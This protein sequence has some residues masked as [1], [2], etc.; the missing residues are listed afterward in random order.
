MKSSNKRK[1]QNKKMAASTHAGM[2]SGLS[3]FR[4][5]YKASKRFITFVLALVLV[6]GL[7][8]VG[9]QRSTAKAADGDLS[10]ADKMNASKTT[11]TALTDDVFV[12]ELYLRTEETTVIVPLKTLT[13][14]T[15]DFSN[16]GNP[17][18]NDFCIW[19]SNALSETWAPVVDSATGEFSDDGIDNISSIDCSTDC[20][21]Y[22]HRFST[23]KNS[24]TNEWALD[25]SSVS[26]VKYNFK[27]EAPAAPTI[28]KS[29][30]VYTISDVSDSENTI[31]Y[32]QYVYSAVLTTDTEITAFDETVSATKTAAEAASDL[33]ADGDAN[34]GTY[35]ITKKILTSNDDFIYGWSGLY[36]RDDNMGDVDFYFTDESDNT[37]T[38]SV[39]ATENVKYCVVNKSDDNIKQADLTITDQGSGEGLGGATFSDLKKDMPVGQFMGNAEADI[40]EH[41][42]KAY[43]FT[44]VFSADGK[45][46]KTVTATL[47]YE[48]VVPKVAI[49]NVS[50]VAYTDGDG[51]KYINGDTAHVTVDFSAAGSSTTPKISAADIIAEPSAYCS[52]TASFTNVAGQTGVDMTVAGVSEGSVDLS[53]NITNSLGVK[54]ATPATQ[55]LIF[56]TSAP[57]I[58]V[59]KVSQGS[60]EYNTEQTS[61]FTISDDYKFTSSQDV[62]MIVHVSDSVSGLAADP[63]A[64]WASTDYTVE[65]LTGGDYKIT[66]PAAASNRGVDPCVQIAATDNVG[67]SETVDVTFSFIPDNVNVTAAEIELPSNGKS[68]GDIYNG[69][70]NLVYT[71]ESDVALNKDSISLTATMNGSAGE[72]LK[73]KAKK[74]TLEPTENTDEYKVVVELAET[75]T[76]KFDNIDFKINNTNGYESNTKRITILKIDMTDPE[77]TSVAPDSSSIAGEDGWYNT[78]YLKIVYSDPTVQTISSGIAS[79]TLNQDGIDEDVPLGSSGYS[80]AQVND[81]KNVNGTKVKVTAVDKVGNDYETDELTYYVDHEFTGDV[82]LIVNSEGAI[83]TSGDFL[84]DEPVINAK[85]SDNIGVKDYSIK[86][87]QNGT[88]LTAYSIPDISTINAGIDVNLK[89]VVEAAGKTLDDGDYVVNATA[90]DLAGNTKNA[91]AVSFTLDYKDPEIDEITVSQ[92]NSADQTISI[93]DGN[94]AFEN[95]VSRQFDLSFLVTGVQDVNLDA[96]GIT[97]TGPNG[98]ITSNYDSTAKTLTFTVS[99]ADMATMGYGTKTFT[100]TLTDAA[101]NVT[102]RDVNIKL[103]EDTIKVTYSVDDNFEQ[104]EDEDFYQG[105][106]SSADIAFVI[107]SDSKVEFSKLNLKVDG[108]DE[109]L[110]SAS[111]TAVKEEDGDYEYTYSYSLGG[112]DVKKEFEFSAENIYGLSDATDVTAIGFDMTT[113]DIDADE[114]IRTKKGNDDWYQNLVLVVKYDDDQGKVWSSGIEAI[115]VESGGGLTNDDKTSSGIDDINKYLEEYLKDPAH[116]KVGQFLIDVDESTLYS[117]GDIRPTEVRIRVKDKTGRT[118]K[119]EQSFKV[120]KHRP[121]VSEFKVE[122]DGNDVVGAKATSRIFGKNTTDATINVKAE[123]NIRLH[124]NKPFIIV[125][126]PTFSGSY[127]LNRNKQY[128]NES[129]SL[130]EIIK[131]DELIDGKYNIALYTEDICGNEASKNPLSTNIWLD[132][133]EPT[134]SDIEVSQVG[135]KAIQKTETGY[136]QLTASSESKSKGVFS[137]KF[138]AE[139]IVSNGYSSKINENGIEIREELSD[140][141]ERLYYLKDSADHK[142]KFDIQTDD[143]YKGKTIKYTI[144]V[145]DGAGNSVSKSLYVSFTTDLIVVNSHTEGL[146]TDNGTK[147]NTFKIIYEIFSA[148]PITKNESAAN[149][150]ADNIALSMQS[151]HDG[152]LNKD[153]AGSGK[154]EKASTYDAANSKYDYVYTYIVNRSDSDKLTDIVMSVTNNNGVKSE[155]NKISYVNIDL[156]DPAIIAEGLPE[157]AETRWYQSLP[158]SFSYNDGIREYISGVA[159]IQISNVKQALGDYFQTKFDTGKPDADG[160]VINGTVAVDVKESEGLQGTVVELQIFDKF[161]RGFAKQYR[162]HV[163]ETNPTVSLSVNG[164][165]AADVNGAYLG[166]DPVDPAVAF[167]VS[168]NIQ[169]QDYNLVI[170][171]PSG[172]TVTAAAGSDFKEF[173]NSTTLAGLIGAENCNGNVPKDGEYTIT[174]SAKD[175]A[176]RVP[177]GGNMSTT[178]VLDNT[179]P[180]NDLVVTSEKPAKFDKYKNAYTNKITNTAYEYGQ[181]YNTDVNFNAIVTD[182]NVNEFVV[183]D[184]GAAIY[185]GSS[186]GTFGIAVS[187]EGEHNIVINTTDKT[188]LT[189]EA[190][191]IS[192]T[193]DRGAPDLGVSLNGS[194]FAEGSGIR[195]LNTN[196]DVSVSVSDANLDDDDLTMTVVTTPPNSGS[197]TSESKVQPGSQSFAQEAEYSVKFV[198][199]DRAGNR[200]AERTVTFRVDK[201]PPELKFTGAAERGT[202]TSS[203]TM[204]YIVNEA[205]YSDM[206]GCSLRVYRKIDG[207]GESLLKTVEIKPSGP[208]YSMSE[209]FQEDGEYRFEMAAEDKCGNKSQASYTFILDSKAPII[210]LTGVGNYDKTIEDVIL[211]I[212]IDETFFSSN[213]VSI[214]GTRIDIDGKKHDVE[215]EGFNANGSKVSTF[216]QIF[217]EDGIYDISI[218]A[219]DKAGNSTSKQLHF[220]I[221][222][223]DPEINGIDDYDGKAVKSFNMNVDPDSM[224]K[225]L[226]VCTT[227]VY[228]DGVE[229]DGT[230]NLSDGAHLLNVVATDELGHTT[231]KKAAFKLDS[232]APN[233]LVSGVEEGQY[234]KVPT[235]INVT[236]ELDTDTLTKVSL[237]GQDIPVNDGIAKFTVDSRMAY[238]LTAEAVDE[239]GNVS[240]LEMHFNFGEKFPW[241][242]FLVGGGGLVLI[243]LVIGISR[244][245]DKKKQ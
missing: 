15:H 20:S 239:A 118:N 192:F 92:T 137:L 78:L 164:R 115:K 185:S 9:V 131:P 150:N 12:A 68:D 197:S 161:G 243:G 49:T 191:S 121:T 36:V 127:K 103:L 80:I 113:P 93:K 206:N 244:K 182:E 97:V 179:A 207:Q 5:H 73:A 53:F 140:G 233:I 212:T 91:T 217:K 76:V 18:K 107:K 163:D 143:S 7:V 89:D 10:F 84:K 205:F 245:K 240:K 67:L 132:Y 22:L 33:S 14:D 75:D 46:D 226:T 152:N 199:V 62:E 112:I 190:A 154:L 195:Y 184:N 77:I 90:K 221:D 60:I 87:K 202:S 231:E 170:T 17:D 134:L 99:A 204:N 159:T 39:D 52:T 81:S 213:K 224:I 193:I 50:T 29:N 136:R 223:T 177:D 100:I 43:D 155:E 139:D 54:A 96:S 194:P 174:L 4:Q 138:S 203:V 28:N 30:Y 37:I 125:T 63:T 130:A 144:T 149:L 51:N 64:K 86:V 220:T 171:L 196:G 148:A 214:S 57:Q 219:T 19:G 168:D 183:T 227:S 21:V 98:E 169:V 66:I 114:S 70:V 225:D 145:T 26:S 119:Y 8:Y 135:N 128:I 162:F 31:Y 178:F 82:D 42:G 69:N 189:S 209:L 229:Y 122:V 208:Q 111:F 156:N 166:G 23:V 234:I 95:S 133:T 24:E 61:D 222:R 45:K 88:D 25:T 58:T 153:T 102:E 160:R 109:T 242:I 181:Y 105:K 108:V 59:K 104:V 215:F 79:I 1:N 72:D 117:N 158:L 187:S 236:V 3:K 237:N 147:D 40:Y 232:T 173:S 175:I 6:L 218:V 210:T 123:D 2:A 200:S 56:D 188:G 172:G 176:G 47:K 180:T 55:T 35:I 141:S 129:V 241:W 116:A 101:G 11:E 110:D 27:Y 238:T 124:S 228:M 65:D 106:K 32:G 71:I 16:V 151:Y 235:E 41:S 142:H 126:G 94:G 157:D 74:I 201:T 120:D 165:S 146:N 34:D 85:A 44:V 211:G 216:E 38:G 198:A 83:V 230:S 186:A 167:A 48:D 13:I